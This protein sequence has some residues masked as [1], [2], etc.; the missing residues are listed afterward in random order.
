MKN[1]T[2]A[3]GVIGGLLL[4]GTSAGAPETA[5]VHIAGIGSPTAVRSVG[6]GTTT[7]LATPVATTSS[8]A[9]ATTAATWASTPAQRTVTS[10][11]RATPSSGSGRKGMLRRLSPVR[12][13]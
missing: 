2:T 6:E 12:P 10:Q 8:A 5:Q 9:P 11:G 13:V 1:I 3:C 4:I 7:T